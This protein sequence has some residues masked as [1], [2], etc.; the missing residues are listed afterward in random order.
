MKKPPRS[1]ISM[2]GLARLAGVSR[3]TVSL[4]L[5]NHP[6]I[7]EARRKEIRALAKRHSY[8]VDPELSQLARAIHRRAAKEPPILA[9]LRFYEPATSGPFAPYVRQFND[10]L[11][12]EVKK[13]GYRLEEF[14]VYGERTT[15][16]ALR[17]ILIARGLKGLIVEAHHP[18]D[19]F[20]RGFDFSSF[21]C[22][23]PAV[24]QASQALPSAG[25]NHFQGTL[26]ALEEAWKRGYRKPALMIYTNDSL[27]NWHWREGAFL[28]FM[29]DKRVA[30]PPPLILSEWSDREVS[31]W[32]KKHRPDV[33]LAPF[34][35]TPALLKKIGFSVPGDL[36][37]GALQLLEPG[38]SDVAGI[39]ERVDVQ[40]G[41]LVDLVIDQMS[42][43]VHGRQ[44]DP[45]RIFISGRWR[46][47]ATL[48]V[49]RKGG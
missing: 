18:D 35:H 46:N 9:A 25:S 20:A 5:R 7:S 4:A 36:A 6:S 2:G 33:L 31:R 21:S 41:A 16:T 48:P 8:V 15:P 43:N 11:I 13:R 44:D 22:A 32:L 47:G 37:F 1:T 3:M 49:R 34:S 38:K 10:T 29:H 19:A 14:H 39:D 45:T 24:D 40:L 27:Q 26:L 17:R 12:Q 30:L 28:Y 23:C 42:R